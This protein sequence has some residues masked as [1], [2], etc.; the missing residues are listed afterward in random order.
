MQR[1]IIAPSPGLRITR[2]GENRLPLPEF[3]ANSKGGRSRSVW[4]TACPAYSC[5]RV[6]ATVATGANTIVRGRRYALGLTDLPRRSGIHAVPG[7][8]ESGGEQTMMGPRPK[9]LH[10]ARD[11]N[12]SERRE[13]TPLLAETPRSGAG[14]T[15]VPEWPRMR[16][17]RGERANTKRRAESR[18]CD[19]G[20]GF[21]L[22]DDVELWSAWSTRKCSGS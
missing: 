13:T 7:S 11:S 17:C 15:P 9:T 21:V 14:Q 8:V 5:D 6:A 19:V 4:V 12:P 10:A 1:P 16:A 22:N 3:R 18:S 2:L 20:P